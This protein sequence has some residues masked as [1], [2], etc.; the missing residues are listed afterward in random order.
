MRGDLGRGRP[1]AEEGGALLIE[2]LGREDAQVVGV[3]R[4]DLARGLAKRLEEE[5]S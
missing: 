5:K 3:K 1:A 4:G 2:I